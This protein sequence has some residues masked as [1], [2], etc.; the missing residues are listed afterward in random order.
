MK[1]YTVRTLLFVSFLFLFFS[2]CTEKGFEVTPTPVTLNT[3]SMTG[4]PILNLGRVLFYDSHLSV[5]NAISCA[6]CHIQTKAFSDNSDFSRGF[7][8]SLTKRNSLPI[9]NLS[10]INM[11]GR[12]PELFWD[13]RENFLSSMV[14]KPILNHVEMGMNDE[15]AIVERV[16]NIPYYKDLFMN[17]FGNS[18]VDINGIGDALATFV[19]TITSSNTKFDQ[20]LSNQANLD[21]LE[22]QGK[23][24]FFQKYNCNS[25]HQTQQSNGYQQ[26]GGFVNIGLD[27]NYSDNGRSII[28]QNPADNGK[29]K[30]PNLRNIALTAPY[31]HDGRFVTLRDVLNHY[32]EG[33][34]DHPNLDVRLRGTDGHAKQMNISEQEKTAL[35]A[36]LNTLTDFTMITNP[37]YSNP[38]HQ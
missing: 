29:F 8:N 25:C 26:G 32:S 23:Q 5:N 21:A 10:T 17:A 3:S 20:F 28:T 2:S 35:I 36:F 24:L 27:L 38:F 6:S 13:G 31:M 7:E 37:A 18:N 33:I 30:I 4:S 22:L 16:R 9:Q 19:G 14:I 11:T 1:T 12:P 15:K 34:A